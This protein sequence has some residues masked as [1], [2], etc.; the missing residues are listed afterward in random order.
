MAE[1][2]DRCVDRGLALQRFARIWCH[3]HPGS[4][5]TP[6]GTDEETFARCF[7]GCDWAVMFILGRTGNTY[8]RLSFSTGPGGQILV[9]VGVDWLHLPRWLEELTENGGT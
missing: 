7:G 1:F 2:F 6:S 8:A 5:V 4:S 3:T 9:P